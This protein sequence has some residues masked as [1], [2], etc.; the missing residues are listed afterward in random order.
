MMKEI[1]MS[2]QAR[3]YYDLY[4]YIWKTRTKLGYAFKTKRGTIRI[5][6]DEPSDKTKLYK[7]LTWGGEITK[8]KG[9]SAPLRS[10]S[11]LTRMI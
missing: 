1:V 10:H 11:S 7:A 9:L 3:A 8:R 2:G 6:V 4:G 5:K